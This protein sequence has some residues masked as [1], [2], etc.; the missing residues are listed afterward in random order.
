MTMT[1]DKLSAK[2]SLKEIKESG[3]LSEDDYIKLEAKMFEIRLVAEIDK[4]YEKKQVERKKRNR[5][6]Y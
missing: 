6:R 5:Y 2:L 1:N 4:W 3:S